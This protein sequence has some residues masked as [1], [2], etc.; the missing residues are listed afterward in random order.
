MI[1]F[2]VN[3]QFLFMLKTYF[4]A[5][6]QIKRRFIIYSSYSLLKLFAGLTNAALTD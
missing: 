1:F 6:L 2:L 4:I 3:N 5:F